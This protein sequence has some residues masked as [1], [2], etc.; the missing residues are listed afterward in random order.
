[1]YVAATPDDPSGSPTWGAW[2]LA[3]GSDV[4]GRAFKFKAE[5]TS[6]NTDVSPSIET[7][8]ATVEY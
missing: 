1:M 2:Q 4:V 8:S 3:N 5:L 7:L 6:T